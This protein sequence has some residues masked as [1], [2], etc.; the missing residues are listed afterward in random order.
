MDPRVYVPAYLERAYE[1]RHTD[2]TPAA[3]E[4][5]RADIAKRPDHYATTEHAQAL[6][7]Y[8]RIREKLLRGLE[9]IEE[10]PDEQFDMKRAQL[11]G[12]TRGE[13]A[14]LLEQ[15]SRVVD[16]KL[17]S[18]LLADVDIDS[19]I[20]D[21]MRLERETQGT[22]A[23]SIAGF[24]IDAP[25]FWSVEAPARGDGTLAAPAGAGQTD[26][27]S[28]GA[29][30]IAREPE[31]IGWLHTLEALSQLCLASARYRAAISYAKTVLRATGYPTHAE[32]TALLA[33][34]RLEDEDGF[35]SFARETQVPLESEGAD[36]VEPPWY[37]LARTLLLYKIGRRKAARRALR[38]FASRCDGG[39]F[40]LLNPTYMTPYLPV[41]PEVD[42]PWKLT[43]QAVWEADGIIADTPDF[44]AWAEEIDGVADAAEAFAARHGF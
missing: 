1:E 10:L 13:L 32:G 17:L 16:A 43:Q 25:H 7:A 30:R 27:R 41:R 36:G 35:F 38:D 44:T 11:F 21:L 18:I 8:L 28:E 26:A 12:Q 34:A 31:L 5:V 37:L 2:L 4:L 40:F 22:L 9:E 15:D 29:R 23:F 19:C 42:E 6:L 3:R 39:A 14:R 20:I 33:L 24:D